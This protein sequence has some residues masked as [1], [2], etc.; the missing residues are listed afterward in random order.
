MD[1][2]SRRFAVSIR[3]PALRPRA[4]PPR[5]T[6]RASAGRAV[7]QIRKVRNGSF[8]SEGPKGRKRRLSGKNDVLP[9]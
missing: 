9:D 4:R 5:G 6:G 8:R 2:L 7:V 3:C 1:F